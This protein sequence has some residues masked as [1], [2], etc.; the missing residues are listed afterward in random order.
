MDRKDI[1]V[2]D[3]NWTPGGKWECGEFTFT[4][5]TP[6]GEIRYEEIIPGPRHSEDHAEQHVWL[7]GEEVDLDL[8]DFPDITIPNRDGSRHAVQFRK[9]MVSDVQVAFAE[10]INEALAACNGKLPVV[11]EEVYGNGP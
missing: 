8:A 10:W 3:I 9:Q 6:I 4:A 2:K 11:K 7:N 5:D 1:K